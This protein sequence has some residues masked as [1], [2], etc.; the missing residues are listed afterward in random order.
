MPLE[1]ASTP[2]LKR[3]AKAAWD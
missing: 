2:A 1:M 3:S